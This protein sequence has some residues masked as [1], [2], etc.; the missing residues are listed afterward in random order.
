MTETKVARVR[1]AVIGG[2]ITGLA[3][4]F[5]LQERGRAAGLPLDVAL[6]E[7]ENSF[8]GKILTEQV[9][10]F[11][12][13]GGPDSFISQKPRA[14]Q[15]CRQIGL[16]EALLGTNDERRKT[17]VVNRGR[18]TPLPDG[19][20][21][22]IPTR[23]LPFALSPLI[24]LGGKMRMGLDLII[25]PRK[26]EGD[27]SLAQFIRRRLGS[28]ALDKIAEPLMSGIQVSV[29]EEQ[30]ILGTFPR[31]RALEAK[32][33]SLTRGILAQRRNGSATQGKAKAQS[34]FLSLSGGL[35]QLVQRLVQQMDGVEMHLN[36][37]ITALARREGGG[38]RIIRAS[39]EEDYADALILATPAYVSAGLTADVCAPL[40]ALLNQIRYVSTATVS[41]GFREEEVGDALNGF[42][43]VVPRRERKNIS[44]CTFTSIKFNQR[45]PQG[46]VLLRC[47]LGGPRHEEQVEWDD[48][49]LVMA[50]RDDLQRL[51]GLDCAPVLK[52]VYRWRKA[53]PQYDVGH[54]Q[55]VQAVH[56]AC[57]DVPGL[58]V[59]G[60]ALE[61]VGIPD[62]ISQG[63]K[64]AEKVLSYLDLPGSVS[65]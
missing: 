20:M 30:S 41:L 11:T 13:E 50:A 64:A 55:H 60:G 39:A 57:Q 56:A 19:V 52:R 29:A 54:P 38:F 51:T 9:D 65:I 2:G 26:D 34:L 59:A 47:F 3:A 4:A 33:G 31:F 16:G 18:L 12:I 24:S 22:I 14:A 61:G 62:C 5:T 45:A 46:H 8:G 10:G 25:P 37:G 58:A 53:N 7:R 27:E 23:F 48:A 1:V 42:G 43:F 44:A 17:Y 28:E 63:E 21:L 15:L 36:A 40:A 6:Y 49:D 32:Y 35:G